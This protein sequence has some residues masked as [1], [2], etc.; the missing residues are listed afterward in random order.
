MT[1]KEKAIDF[2]RRKKMDIV[3]SIPDWEIIK[4][5]VCIACEETKKEMEMKY[6][7][8]IGELSY[9]HIRRNKKVRVETA[10]E[11][12]KWFYNN[13]TALCFDEIKF[14]KRF[15]NEQ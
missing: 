9:Q 14:N 8:I 3:V 13:A 15:L 5:A 11:I 4:S 2:L 1:P 6:D 12:K 10:K 7:L